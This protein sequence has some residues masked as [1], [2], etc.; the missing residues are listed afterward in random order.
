MRSTPVAGEVTEGPL[1][2]KGFPEQLRLQNTCQIEGG[3]PL[4]HWN[5]TVAAARVSVGKG[6][7]TAIGFGSLFNDAAMGYHWLVEPDAEMRQRYDG[8]YTLLRAALR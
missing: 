3:Q 5:D 2:I 1:K 8:L 7:V 4:A 6:S